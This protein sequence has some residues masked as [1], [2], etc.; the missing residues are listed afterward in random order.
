MRFYLGKRATSGALAICTVTCHERIDD[1]TLCPAAEE[2]L[3][4]CL[5]T[6]ISEAGADGYLRAFT[7]IAGSSHE[8][9]SFRERGTSF[10]A[11][12]IGL[13]IRLDGHR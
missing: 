1:E 7:R 8:F 6:A 12:E 10:E 13:I 5:D 9:P 11:L 3:A 4:E 2:L